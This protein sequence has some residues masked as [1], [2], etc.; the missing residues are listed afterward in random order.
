MEGEVTRLLIVN[1]EAKKEQDADKLRVGK[2]GW[3][4]DFIW[5]DGAGYHGYYVEGGRIVERQDA[6]NELMKHH[7]DCMETDYHE[8]NPEETRDFQ[9]RRKR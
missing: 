3:L 9:A 7:Q 5:Y 6:L 1:G 2:L 4:A 8:A